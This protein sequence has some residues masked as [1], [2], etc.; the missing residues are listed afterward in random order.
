MQTRRGG[1]GKATSIEVA[2]KAG[3]SQATVS[4]VFNKKE[5]INTD[6]QKRVEQA[7]KEL[8]YMPNAIARSLISRKTNLI[9]LVTV[10]SENPHYWRIASHLSQKFANAG[11]QI[12]YCECDF[13]QNINDIFFQVM[14]YQVDGVIIMSAAVS[15]EITKECARVNIPV[16]IFNRYLTHPN[17]CTVCSD[18]VGAGALV[19]DYLAAKGYD[20]FGYIG[21][22]RLLVQIS[23][24][25]QRGFAQ[26][27]SEL[28]LSFC[29][30]EYGDYSYE[31]GKAAMHR[32]MQAKE[33]PRAIFCANDLMAFGAMDAAR[34]EMGLK[35]PQD[36]AIVGF[37]GLQESGWDSYRL[38]TVKQS[39]DYM[40]D[41]AFDYL[42][43]KMDGAEVP[44]SL[45]LFPCEMI[46]RETA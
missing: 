15:P 33:R 25:R 34:T 2:K 18:N 8:G 10:R 3:V 17:F 19:A 27:L 32:L 14:Q 1:E 5:N 35:I 4:R 37:D 9:A 42:A 6:T 45:K 40:I 20:S 23:S 43:K 7:A 24:D 46:E 12:L 21:T 36:V 30:T 29:A 22:D 39:V 13:E 28:S 11:K 41:E 31:S 26:R 38:T 44:G 16:V